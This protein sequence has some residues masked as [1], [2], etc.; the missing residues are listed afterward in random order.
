MT[1]TVHP[2]GVLTN[3]EDTTRTTTEWQSY[4]HIV[5]TRCVIR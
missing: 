4:N 2:D 1:P 3:G 5:Q